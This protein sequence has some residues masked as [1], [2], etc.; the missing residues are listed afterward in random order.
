MSRVSKGGR[1]CQSLV[2]MSGVAGMLV[3]NRLSLV[4]SAKAAQVSSA[5]AGGAK[6]VIRYSATQAVVLA[7]LVCLQPGVLD[8]AIVAAYINGQFTRCVREFRVYMRASG[9]QNP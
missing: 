7:P 9:V 1:S 8:E 3:A 4:C 2:E 5:G 6:A